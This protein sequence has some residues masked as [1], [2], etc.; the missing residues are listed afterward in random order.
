MSRYFHWFVS[1]TEIALVAMSIV[2]REQMS[3][4]LI[5]MYLEVKIKVTSKKYGA[6]YI[7]E[8]LGIIFGSNLVSLSREAVGEF[9]WLFLRILFFLLLLLPVSC[10]CV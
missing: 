5:S 8:A 3:R 2:R 1:L 10:I 7:N 6:E 9:I 4:P